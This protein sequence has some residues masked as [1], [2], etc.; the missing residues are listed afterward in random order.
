MAVTT[1]SF[2]LFA[3]STTNESYLILLRHHPERHCAVDGAA[4][5]TTKSKEFSF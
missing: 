2:L 5:K 1:A 4:N 3:V